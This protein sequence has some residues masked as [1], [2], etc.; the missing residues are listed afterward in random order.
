M[1]VSAKGLLVVYYSSLSRGTY[2]YIKHWQKIY[3]VPSDI[4]EKC[5]ALKLSVKA[6]D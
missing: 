6:D 1:Q 5:G 2:K 3:S 4:M